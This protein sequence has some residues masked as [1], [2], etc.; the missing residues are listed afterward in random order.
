MKITYLGRTLHDSKGRFTSL[1]VLMRKVW[2]WTKISVVAGLFG[3]IAYSL[4]V[5][6]RGNTVY[7]QNVI[8]TPQIDQEAPILQRISDCE[9]GN[10]TKGSGKHFKNGQVIL[11]VN[12]NGTIDIGKF[13]INSTW[14]KQATKLGFDLTKEKDNY[15]MAKWIY[16]NRGTSDWLSSATC[17]ML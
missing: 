11:H 6:D 7:A 2:F 9:S 13:Q 15:A 10:G 12:S 17:W 4:G 5:A 14:G 8:V 16:E 3:V 1:K